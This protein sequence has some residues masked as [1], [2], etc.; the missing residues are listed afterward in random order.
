[1]VLSSSSVQAQAIVPG[2]EALLAKLRLNESIDGLEIETY[3]TITGDPYLYKDFHEGELILQNG[4]KYKLNLRF[5][6]YGNQV[7]LKNNENIF[8]II[9]PERIALIIIDTVKF[10]YCN[11][12]KSP[13][14]ESSN[15]SSYFIL[16]TDGKCKLLLRKNIRIQDA[17]PPRPYQEAKPAKFVHTGDTY[18]IKLG[19]ENAVLIRNKKDIISVL[20]DQKEA[21]KKFI[22]SNKSN[23]KNI[24]D[25]I[26]IVD[27]YN[28]L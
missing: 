4:G 10:F 23:L 28:N 9:H 1:V 27:Y 8:G 26:G 11:Y 14:S 20:T 7:H 22:K 2:S 24:E 19:Q 25:L 18:Y 6:I 21:L 17:E 3:E 12:V 5:D 16:K 15:H 13:G